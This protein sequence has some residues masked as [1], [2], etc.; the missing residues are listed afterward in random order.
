MEIAKTKV[1][2][3]KRQPKIDT[4]ASFVCCCALYVG[5]CVTVYI[6]KLQLPRLVSTNGHQQNSTP[7][8]DDMMTSQ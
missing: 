8:A 6:I 1:N 7:V 3:Q 2:R 5:V 4:C